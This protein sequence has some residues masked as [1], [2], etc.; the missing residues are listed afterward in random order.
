GSFCRRRGAPRRVPDRL[1]DSR[2][3]RRRRWY[4]SVVARRLEF[5]NTEAGSGKLCSFVAG[6]CHTSVWADASRTTHRAPG[7]A[8][9]QTAARLIT[10]RFSSVDASSVND[11]Y[12]AI[13]T[14][15]SNVG[16]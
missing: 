4:R 11:P 2:R 16:L 6:S 1:G 5:E 13:R 9:S 3:P 14:P 12:A 8:L 7:K 15:P 10:P